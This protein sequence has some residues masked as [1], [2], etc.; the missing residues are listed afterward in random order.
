MPSPLFFQLL[1]SPVRG[2]R[3]VEM[4]TNRTSKQAVNPLTRLA[5]RSVMRR[6][7]LSLHVEGPAA[8]F[9][10]LPAFCALP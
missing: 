2:R 10:P 3:T 5:S 1:R 8:T 7:F 9:D 6:R 4:V